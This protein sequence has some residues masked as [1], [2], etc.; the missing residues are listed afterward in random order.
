MQRVVAVVVLVGLAAGC[1]GDDDNAEST[2]IPAAVVTTTEATTPPTSAPPPTT[3][4]P[5]TEPPP[6]TEAS[7]PTTESPPTTAPPPSTVDP[8]ANL[9]QSVARDAQAGDD[10]L[11]E[12]LADPSASDG[13]ERL[14]QYFVGEALERA[15]DLLEQFRRDDLVVEAHPTVQRTFGPAGEPVLVNGPPGAKVEVETCRLDSDIVLVVLEDTDLRVPVNDT[16]S[17][18][19]AVSVFLLSDGI[20]QLESWEATAESVGDDPCE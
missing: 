16:I 1:S 15:L 14:R 13:E 3:V 5:T 19:E 6:T 20:W 2:T 17:R 9:A 7:P 8:L 18:T 12:V 11:F 4:P 10:V